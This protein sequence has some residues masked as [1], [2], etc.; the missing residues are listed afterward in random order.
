MKRKNII[1]AVC[2]VI[3]CALIVLGTARGE[4]D[5]VLQKAV[6]LCLE[7]IGIG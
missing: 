3:G 7:C 6:K 2:L 4:P 1:R 5:T